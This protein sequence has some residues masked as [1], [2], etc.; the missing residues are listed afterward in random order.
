[1]LSKNKSRISYLLKGVIMAFVITIILLVFFS[2]LL[3]F[4]S[5]SESRLHLLNNLTMIFSLAISSL[6]AAIKIKEKGWLHGGIV[7]LLYYLVI[8]LINLIF[9]RD[10]EI[11]ILL[12][13]LL[14]SVV[15][16]II[17]GM[18]GINLI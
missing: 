3:R 14:I 11:S 18:I 4:T 16:G 1:M 8:F 9:I 15:T 10:T 13:K 7:G 17:G 12:S 5:L 2:L 6:Y